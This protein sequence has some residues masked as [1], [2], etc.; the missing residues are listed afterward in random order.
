[1]S[2]KTHNLI[3]KLF[4]PN[5]C[6]LCLLRGSHRKKY[7][8]NSLS[9]EVS[10][11]RLKLRSNKPTQQ[12]HCLLDCSRSSCVAK[13]TVLYE[14]LRDQHRNNE[15]L[16]TYSSFYCNAL[17]KLAA[18]KFCCQYSNLHLNLINFS[19]NSNKET[20]TINTLPLCY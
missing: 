2:H 3:S 10:G 6:Q 16:C 9:F 14:L 15:G 13:H 7:F 17:N 8:S 18:I 20:G 12:Q 1:M 19:Q 11:I 5:F 4:T